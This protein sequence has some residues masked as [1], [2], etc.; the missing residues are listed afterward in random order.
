M[1][2]LGVKVAWTLCLS[3][4]RGS[5]L[6]LFS[7]FRFLSN[8]ISSAAPCHFLKRIEIGGGGAVLRSGRGGMIQLLHVKH[9][10]R[11]GKA[12]GFTRDHSPELRGKSGS[13]GP[14][15]HYPLPPHIC[16]GTGSGGCW[17]A[18]VRQ[19]RS[20]KVSPGEIS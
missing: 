7:C 4:D 19:M 10:W 18:A 2:G 9:I 14:H 12:P 17:E 1:D 16:E 3:S 5:G 11:Q 13:W 20:R 6:L 8:H 15:Y